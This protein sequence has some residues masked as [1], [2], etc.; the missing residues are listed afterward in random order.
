[1]RILPT[2]AWAL[3]LAPAAAPAQ[4]VRDSL[5]VGDLICEFGSGGQRSLLADL[6]NAPRTSDLLLVYED[7]TRKSAQVLSTG[8]PGRRPVLVRVTEQAVH[9]IE[10]VG[11][12]VRVTTLTG[13]EQLRPRR[14]RP[15]CV[16]YAA[17]HAWLFDERVLADPDRAYAELPSGAGMWRCEP[18][19]MD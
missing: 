9:F 14:G 16:R 3:A 2:L 12:S 1:M 18:W 11:P 15:T 4:G 8:A 7:V 10:P 13:C 17:R 19:Q 6:V 5:Q